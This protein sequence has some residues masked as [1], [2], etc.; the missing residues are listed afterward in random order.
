M[1]YGLCSPYCAILPSRPP[2]G[3]RGLK[4]VLALLPSTQLGSSPSRGTWIEMTCTLLV[5]LMTRGRPPRGGRGLKYRCRCR[6]HL[7]TRRPPRGGRGL[8]SSRI[9]SEIMAILSS[10]S[11]GTWIEISLRHTHGPPARGRP[12]RGGRGLKFF[13]YEKSIFESMSS[14][15]RGTWIEIYVATR[16]RPSYRRRPPRGGRGLK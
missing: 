14:P 10:P 1:K 6:N 3:G 16:K 9:K 4:F 8:K 7:S 12:P 5:R 15:S 11:R 13:I 2:R